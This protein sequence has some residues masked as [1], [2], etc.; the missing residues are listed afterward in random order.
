MHI[1]PSREL[2]KKIGLLMASVLVTFILFIFLGF[3]LQ[4]FNLDETVAIGIPE[5]L[6]FYFWGGYFLRK[7]GWSKTLG[8][9]LFLIAIAL[10]LVFISSPYDTA[11]E[12][13]ATRV[14]LL[15]SLLASIFLILQQSKLLRLLGAL[16]IILTVL[17]A[18]WAAIFFRA[19][20]GN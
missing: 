18:F 1:S 12:F 9:I 10:N 19:N 17:G 2:L 14:F 5:I 20:L 11:N 3:V 16:V 15:F 7:Q 6:V 4:Y 13:K 8:N